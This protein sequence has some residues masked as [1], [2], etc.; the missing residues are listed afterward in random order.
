MRA[1][2]ELSC[3]TVGTCQSTRTPR[4]RAAVGPIRSCSS[5]SLLDA[6]LVAAGAWVPGATV[7]DDDGEDRG[8][9]A[10][11]VRVP[12]PLQPAAAPHAARIIRNCVARMVMI[13]RGIE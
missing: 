5:R 6:L 7:P 4:L 1:M 12:V 2:P 9:S 11:W 13:A 10:L 8:P 3:G